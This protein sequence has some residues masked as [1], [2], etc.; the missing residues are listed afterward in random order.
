MRTAMTIRKIHLFALGFIICVFALLCGCSRNSG[1][2][3]GA[4]SSISRNEERLA[5]GIRPIKDSWTQ[6]RRQY[7]T[8]AWVDANENLCKLVQATPTGALEWEED[9]YL[10]GRMYTTWDGTF[11]EKLIV[12]YDY[13]DRS[14]A[15]FY[16]GTNE[17]IRAMIMPFEKYHDTPANSTNALLTADPVLAEWGMTRL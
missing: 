9:Y 10:S 11:P 8:E 12:H 4:T 7:R 15:V 17:A 13:T 1:E 2:P 16:L 5:I 3:L 14:V 6:L